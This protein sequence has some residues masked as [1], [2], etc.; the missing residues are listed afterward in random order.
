ME[1]VKCFIFL[2]YVTATQIRSFHKASLCKGVDATTLE[3]NLTMPT[4]L[5]TSHLFPADNGCEDHYEA[6]ED[7]CLRI[8][9]FPKSFT[10]AI[11]TCEREGSYL[12]H[13]TSQA[14]HANLTQTLSDKSKMFRYRVTIPSGKNIPL[15]Q[16]WGMVDCYCSQ[17]T[18]HYV[19]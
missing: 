15:T 18:S 2:G 7:L 11:A 5:C 13:V 17:W 12:A 14:V 1:Y 19:T 4:A 9:P 6:V 8:S 10:D 16:I 3:W